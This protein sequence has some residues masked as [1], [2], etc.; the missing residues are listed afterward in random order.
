MRS[1]EN[2]AVQDS[3]AAVVDQIFTSK[4]LLCPAI[5]VYHLRDLIKR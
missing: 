2:S 4:S 1:E 3:S 5:P